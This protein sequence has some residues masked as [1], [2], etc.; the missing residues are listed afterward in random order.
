[1]PEQQ[2]SWAW[3]TACSC[4]GYKVHFDVLC[5]DDTIYPRVWH[6]DTEQEAYMRLA[7]LRRLEQY[8]HLQR[9]ASGDA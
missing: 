8:R 5:P 4:G 7:N 9:E 6:V 3:V 2:D 1:M